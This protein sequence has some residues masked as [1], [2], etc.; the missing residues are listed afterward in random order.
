MIAIIAI[1]MTMVIITGG[2]DLSV[3]S[4]IALSAVLAA[5]FIRDAAG[6]V[7]ASPAGNDRSPASP[8]SCC[9]GSSARSRAR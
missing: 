1:G 7:D 8:R 6:G 3:G 2:I 5:M 4:L 9:A